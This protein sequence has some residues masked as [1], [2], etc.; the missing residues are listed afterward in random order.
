MSIF[1]FRLCAGSEET[2]VIGKSA[3]RL[4]DPPV[5]EIFSALDGMFRVLYEGAD[6]SILEADT[7][8]GEIPPDYV[9]LPTDVDAA[10]KRD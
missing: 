10:L 5:F 6:G 1:P 2:D 8:K 3:G 7:L 9:P 4:I